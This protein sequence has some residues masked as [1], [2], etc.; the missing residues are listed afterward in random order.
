M[1]LRQTLQGAVNSRE[2]TL[3]NGRC[4]RKNFDALSAA[5]GRAQMFLRGYPFASDERCR[6]WCRANFSDVVRIVPGNQPK[7]LSSLTK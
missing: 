6:D 2:A 1:S 4:H 7:V 5:I 3:R